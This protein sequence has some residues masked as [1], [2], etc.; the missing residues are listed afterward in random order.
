M[1][2]VDGVVGLGFKMVSRLMGDARLMYPNNAL[3]DRQQGRTED[4]RWQG[5]C[6][7]TR[8]QFLHP[9]GFNG[10]GGFFQ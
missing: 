5:R 8:L 10:R 3:T 9:V 1:K 4:V 2:F 7:V 6:Q